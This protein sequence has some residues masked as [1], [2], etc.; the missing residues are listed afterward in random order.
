MWRR[1]D[2]PQRHAAR[3]WQGVEPAPACVCL[4]P[5]NGLARA[6]EM[7][8]YQRIAMGEAIGAS[9][10][11]DRRPPR[12][13]PPSFQ[14]LGDAVTRKDGHVQGAHTKQPTPFCPTVNALTDWSTATRLASRIVRSLQRQHPLSNPQAV[15]TALQAAHVPPFL[16]RAVGAPLFEVTKLVGSP[17]RAPRPSL[18]LP[19]NHLLTHMPKNPH[20]QSCHTA[21]MVK[22]HARARKRPLSSLPTIRGSCLCRPSSRS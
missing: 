21:N 1:S 3:D 4:H 11:K 14:H 8:S 9:I 19:R 7:N 6:Y 17:F 22:R 13:A 2:L 12:P 15:F 5:A 10:V 20:C 18:T 16:A